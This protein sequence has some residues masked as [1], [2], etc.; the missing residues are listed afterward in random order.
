MNKVSSI[1]YH[2][3]LPML[4]VS[5]IIFIGSF[6]SS[7]AQA[8]TQLTQPPGTQLAFYIGFHNYYGG[9]YNPVYYGP[10]YYRYR[11]YWT[12]WR[13]IGHG[14]RQSCL[15]DRWNGRVIRCSRRC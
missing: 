11:T 7:F 15:I 5:F 3:L 14:C 8:N 4:I 1:Q 2:K 9:Y 12:G 10:R 6:Y 13:Y